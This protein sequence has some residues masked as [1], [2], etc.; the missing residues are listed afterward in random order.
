LKS[1]EKQEEAFEANYVQVYKEYSDLRVNYEALKT[2]Q[3]AELEEIKRQHALE[4]IATDKR[5]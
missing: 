5:D 1:L 3:T 4:M 2:A